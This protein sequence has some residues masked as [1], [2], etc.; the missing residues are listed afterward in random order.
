MKCSVMIK[1]LTESLRRFADRLYSWKCNELWKLFNDYSETDLL[2][3]ITPNGITPN[4]ITSNEISWTVLL[5]TELLWKL[6]LSKS[7][8]AKNKYENRSVVCTQKI[9]V[10]NFFG[11]FIKNF[12]FDTKYSEMS[13]V[14]SFVF[15]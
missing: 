13:C 5:R 3:G 12:M 2:N 10:K 9:S 8:H 14:M 11:R 15:D 7:V 6:F 1:W 4:G